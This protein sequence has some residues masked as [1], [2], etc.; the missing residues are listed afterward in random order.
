[1]D[2]EQIIR[3]Q[4]SSEDSVQYNLKRLVY[5]EYEGRFICLGGKKPEIQKTMWFD[6]ERPIPKKTKEM[7]IH[8]NE[9]QS[10]PREYALEDNR[11]NPLIVIPQY[12]NDK[13]DF[14]LC[15]LTYGAERLDLE[16]PH[17]RVTQELLEVINAK[18]KELQADYRKRLE[19]YWKRYSDNVSFCGYWVNR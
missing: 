3:E 12:W 13:T 7:F 15:S 1:M 8:I 18:G 6:D 2:L 16:I 10:S 5:V 11:Q 4:Y 19:S 17:F 9:S 14:R